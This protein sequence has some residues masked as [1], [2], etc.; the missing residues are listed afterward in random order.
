MSNVFAV[1]VL[2]SIV[3]FFC[4]GVG[5]FFSN[6]VR[7]DFYRYGLVW[8][9]IPTGVL[10]LLASVGLIFGLTNSWLM[11]ISAAFLAIMML[12]ALFVRVKIG[13]SW[14]LRVPALFYLLLNLFIFLEAQGFEQLR[15]LLLIF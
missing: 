6:Q 4:Y 7:Q 15:K 11:Q 8:L 5:C 12:A 3:S 1:S 2:V 14:L 10:Q 13:D 9:R